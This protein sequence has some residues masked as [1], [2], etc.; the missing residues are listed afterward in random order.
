MKQSIY[1][2]SFFFLMSCATKSTSNKNE[3]LINSTS[4]VNVGNDFEIKISKIIS[5]SRCPENVTCVWAGEVQ[6]ELEI[7]KNQKLENSQT[8]SINYK[9][10]EENKTFFAKYISKDKKIKEIFI[11]P[12]KKEG[13]NIEL[14]NYVLKVE[15]E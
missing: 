15:L 8:I 9:K 5:D 3:I 2:L 7:Y 1:I 10:L 4:K 14:K 11:S 13:Q 12:S 6:L